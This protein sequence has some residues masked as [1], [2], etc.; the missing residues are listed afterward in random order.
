MPELHFAE[1]RCELVCWAFECTTC[2]FVLS[3]Q[4]AHSDY[5]TRTDQG[6]EENT[7]VAS[8]SKEAES[9][10]LSMFG[11]ILR[12]HGSDSDNRSSKDATQTSKQCHMPQGLA[13][14]KESRSDRQAQ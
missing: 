12:D 7:H 5:K 10:C 13:H 2:R 8:E 6:T 4:P 3:S 1:C 9:P 11:A 14:S